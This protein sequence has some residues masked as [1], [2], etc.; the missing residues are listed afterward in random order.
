MHSENALQGVHV[1]PCGERSVFQCLC[2]HIPR[3]AVSLQ[4]DDDH[5]PLAIYAKQVDEPSEV[6]ADH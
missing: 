3:R 2:D 1:E 4:L 6:G 5:V